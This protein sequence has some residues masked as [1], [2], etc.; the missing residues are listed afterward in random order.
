MTNAP[1]TTS[2]FPETGGPVNDFGDGGQSIGVA[3]ANG[4]AVVL[5]WAE[6]PGQAVWAG[7]LIVVA[8]SA[9]SYLGT[10]LTDRHHRDGRDA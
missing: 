10:H 7:V 6:A 9:V 5:T 1:D 2:A 8:V 3:Q 4:A